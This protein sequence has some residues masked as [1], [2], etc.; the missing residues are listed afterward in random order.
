MMLVKF[1]PE[2]SGM[3]KHPLVTALPSR[4]ECRATVRVLFLSADVTIDIRFIIYCCVVNKRVDKEQFNAV[5]SRCVYDNLPSVTQVALSVTQHKEIFLSV[6]R[7]N[8][9]SFNKIII[10]LTTVSD[11]PTFL[12]RCLPGADAE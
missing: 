12:T 8:S 7:A 6:I 4:I 5:L 11:M 10:K 1:L 3:F 2:I 9:T